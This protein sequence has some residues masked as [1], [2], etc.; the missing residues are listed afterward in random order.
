MEKSINTIRFLAIDTI[1]KEILGEAS[2]SQYQLEEQVVHMKNEFGEKLR[3]VCDALEAANLEL[4]DERETTASLMKR[5]ES[6]DHLEE[7]WT[8]RQKELD[9][10]KKMFEESS[11]CQLQLEEQNSLIDSD[12]ERKLTEVCNALEKANSELVEK[13]CEGHEID[14]E[15]W[16]WKSITD[17]LK[18]DLEESQELC[19]E[20]EAF[21]LAQVLVGEIIKREKNKLVNNF[22]YEGEANIKEFMDLW[23]YSCE[24]LRARNSR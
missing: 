3:E 24:I 10:Y 13:I 23:D 17:P 14:F 7:Q 19:K 5:I 4:A 8:L 15:L 20:L 2:M 1:V 18:V 12:S 21:L 22:C 6:L 11:R 9:R 16:I